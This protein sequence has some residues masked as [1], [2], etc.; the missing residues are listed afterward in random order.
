MRIAINPV[1]V[2]TDDG[3]VTCVEASV[4]CAVTASAAIRLTPLGPDGTAYLDA[5]MPIVIPAGSG[6]AEDVAFMSAVASAVA[7]LA[8]AKGA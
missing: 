8:Q 3:N 2:A 5:D 1:T 4:S 7:T 6:R